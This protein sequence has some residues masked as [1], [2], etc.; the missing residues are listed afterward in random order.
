MI[1]PASHA[2]MLSPCFS[3]QSL[4][5]QGR[6]NIPQPIDCLKPGCS[7]RGSLQCSRRM[8]MSCCIVSPS[9]CRLHARTFSQISTRQSKLPQPSATPQPDE[10]PLELSSLATLINFTTQFPTVRFLEKERQRDE[11][12]RV[13]DALFQKF[14]DEDEQGYQADFAAELGVQQ[15]TPRHL[16]AV[17]SSSGLGDDEEQ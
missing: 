15:N 5:S 16:F 4:T 9:G 6:V 13:R 12:E 10:P 3:S 17:P 11:D 14:E 8:G 7:H 2:F 1:N